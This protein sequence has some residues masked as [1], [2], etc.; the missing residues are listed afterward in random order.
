M[1]CT[2]WSLHNINVIVQTT[3]DTLKKNQIITVGFWPKLTNRL[4]L[5]F[6]ILSGFK[7]AHQ[8]MC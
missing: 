1:S 6:F 5:P 8:L 7:W 3:G 4:P 2:S